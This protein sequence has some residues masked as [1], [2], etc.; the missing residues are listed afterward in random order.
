MNCQDWVKWVH[1]QCYMSVDILRC[2]YT[3]YSIRE[4][5]P[6]MVSRVAPYRPAFWKM[7]KYCPGLKVPV[8]SKIYPVCIGDKLSLT[9]LDLWHYN[10]DSFKVL[11]TESSFKWLFKRVFLKNRPRTSQICHQHKLTSI[12]VTNIEV[13]CKNFR[14]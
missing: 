9:T 4:W 10:V 8:S 7:E 2:I 13:T 1:G 6:V 12:S 3:Q 5:T 14:C 11:V